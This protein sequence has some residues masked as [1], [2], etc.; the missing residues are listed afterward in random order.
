M[1]NLVF[2]L[3]FLPVLSIGQKKITLPSLDGLLIT[4][5]LYEVANSSEVLIL[6]HQAGSSRGEYCARA[7]KLND[8]GFTCLAIDQRSG[9]TMK[10]VKNETA[11]RAKEKSLK[12]GFLDAEQDVVAAINYAYEAYDKKVILVG[13]SYSAALT[14]KVGVE[15]ANKVKAVAAFS[16]GEY[17]G[18]KYKV[19]QTAKKLKQPVYITSSKSE[20]DKAGEIFDSI[21]SS[22]K[23]H[24]IPKNAGKHGASALMEETENNKEYWESFTTFLNSI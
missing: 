5:D 21:A 11:E 24:F 15:H 7:K 18:E 12:I 23:V 4:A 2:L 10:S 22:K 1:K 3:I 13:S 19:G 17:F 9:N 14:I 16:P 8:L 20:S 6:C